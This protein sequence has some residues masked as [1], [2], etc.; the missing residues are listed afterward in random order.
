MIESIDIV[1]D[2]REQ[3]P[4][5]F[6]GVSKSIK[7]NTHRTALKTGDYT[8]S[9]LENVLALER[10][11]SLSEFAGNISEPRFKREL[12]RLEAFK[13]RFLILEFGFWHINHWEDYCKTLPF[14]QTKLSSQFII[15]YLSDIEVNYNLHVALCND[16]A[17][18]EHYALNIMRRVYEREKRI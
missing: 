13:Y 6:T 7:V 15:R 1:V 14:M 9:G 8:V 4:W 3:Q 12:E 2:T 16:R 10:K 11:K 18:A 17:S 5:T